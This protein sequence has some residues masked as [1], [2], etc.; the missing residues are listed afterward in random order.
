VT[1]DGDP[2]DNQAGA[3]RDDEADDG[4]ADP[5][6]DAMRAVWLSM[7]DE[8]PPGRGLAE[9]MAA[10]R[11]QAA[12]MEPSPSPSPSPSLWHRVLAALRRPPVLALATALV[13]IG[14][15]ALV[16]LR[17]AALQPRRDAAI[18]R[19]E[20]S[21]ARSIQP[22]PM[23]ATDPATP[24]AAA[25]GSAAGAGASTAQAPTA[26][27]E[28]QEQSAAG[29][30]DAPRQPP[31]PVAPRPSRTAP[32]SSSDTNVHEENATPN[33]QGASGPTSDSA[34]E[35][36][37]A[38]AKASA[39]RAVNRDAP[40]PGASA[41]GKA[42]PAP[43]ASPPPEAEGTLRGN[44]RRVT[45]HRPAGRAADDQ[46]P[47]SDASPPDAQGSPPAPRAPTARVERLGKDC[48][49]AAQRGDCANAYRLLGQIQQ[50]DRA[51]ADRLSNEA[52]LQRC[53]E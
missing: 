16:A 39:E 5:K 35:R 44:S 10:A 25:Q 47:L 51:Y 49:A 41:G 11:N 43:A 26:T 23:A 52:A 6:L 32:Q 50:M 24:M 14:G 18:V 8:E 42:D 28:V 27:T 45:T 33:G 1:T 40:K 3:K 20:S 31:V 2:P 48:V 19:Q 15:G 37:N 12:A 38:D 30:R 22:P 17:P 21:T 34:A 4:S 9:L 53:L 36:R 7:R 29:L 46:A 13:L